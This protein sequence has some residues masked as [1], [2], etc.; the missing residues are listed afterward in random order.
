MNRFGS[1]KVLGAWVLAAFLFV[2]APAAWSQTTQTPEGVKNFAPVTEMLYRGAQPSSTGFSALHHMGVGIVVNFRNEAQETSA[3]QREVES[4]GMKYVGIPWSGRDNPSD[5][6]V[7][8]FLDLVRANPQTKI[9]VHC[10]RGADRTGTMVAA[11]RIAVQHQAV[12]DAVAEMHSFHYD[13]FFLPQLERYV[14]SLPRVLH[15]DPLFAAYLSAPNVVAGAA[16]VAA[17]AATVTATASANA[18]MTPVSSPRN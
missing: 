13:H 17:A 4:L 1:R 10:Q 8:Q 16:N 5:A 14:V 3:E 15:D 9:F 2:A 7:V 6:Q 18:A 12:K 11:Y